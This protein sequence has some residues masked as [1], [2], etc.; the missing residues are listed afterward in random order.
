VVDEHLQDVVD[1]RLVGLKLGALD[2]S[3]LEHAAQQPAWPNAVD[4][5]GKFL[6]IANTLHTRTCTH[7][8][9]LLPKSLPDVL[10]VKERD[11]E[12]W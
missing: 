2:D 4:V 8:A 12:K 11:L 1:V 9:Q 5:V 3:A 7:N 6:G 10:R